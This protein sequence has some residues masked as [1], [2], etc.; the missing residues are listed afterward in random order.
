MRMCFVNFFMSLSPWR[1]AWDFCR[2][3]LIVDGSF[4]KAYYKGTLLTACGQDT[5]GHIVP[6]AFRICDSESKA[7]WN[8]FLSQVHDCIAF[9]PD[10]FIVS[11]K[12]EGILS[13]V[14]DI[15][16]HALHEYC[17]E[18]LRHNMVPKFRGADKNLGWKFKAAYM[19]STQKEFEEYMSLLDSEDVH[20]RPWLR[21]IDFQKWAKCMSGLLIKI[22]LVAIY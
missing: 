5:N 3:V 8:W 12:H 6:L 14:S 15:F 13:D 11:D 9:Q 4:M 16:S 10:M 2:P 20:I 7:S 17:V 21:K 19:T 18:H 22:T 1:R